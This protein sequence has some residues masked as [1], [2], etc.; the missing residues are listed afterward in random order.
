M[1]T[2]SPARWARLKYQKL[3][4]PER[5]GTRRVANL[6]GDLWGSETCVSKGSSSPPRSNARRIQG[7]IY[8]EKANKWSLGTPAWPGALMKVTWVGRTPQI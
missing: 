1:E 5:W 4:G 3:K 8:R 7:Y 2:C 6:G